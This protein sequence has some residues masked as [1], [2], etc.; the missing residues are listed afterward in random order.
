[1]NRI[2]QQT[3]Q[4][5]EIKPFVIEERVY[6]RTNNIHIKQRSKKLNNKSIKPFKIKRNIKELS[7]ELDLL[8]KMQ[9]HSVFHAFMLQCCNQFISLQIIKTSVKLNE[10]YQVENILEK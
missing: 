3:E 4:T 7:Y 5:T 8:N 9:I 6:L 10:K 2:Q 1:M